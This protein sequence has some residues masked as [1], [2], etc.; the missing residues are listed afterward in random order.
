MKN[1]LTTLSKRIGGAILGLSLLIGVV[2]TTTLTAQAQY[3]N[4]DQ[5]RR[6]RDWDRDQRRRDDRDDRWRDRDDRWRDD[7][8]VGRQ[9]DYRDYGGSYQLRQTALNAGYNEGI[10]E[11]RKDR[12]NGSRYDFRDKSAFQHADK[13]YSS[14]LGDRWIYERYFRD[15]YQNGYVAGYNGY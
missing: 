11:G 7:R 6:N 13:D 14:R 12:R 9:R 5:Y 2:A 15:A 8:T 10:K 4:N 1:T 3:P